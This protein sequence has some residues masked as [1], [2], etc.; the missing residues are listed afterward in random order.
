MSNKEWSDF[1]A[2]KEQE[3]VEQRKK[4]IKKGYDFYGKRLKKVSSDLTGKKY[5]SST[6][7]NINK[8]KKN[9]KN[10]RK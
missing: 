2:K 7:K 4:L 8:Q 6:E 1:K 9:N 3:G 10:Q 5:D